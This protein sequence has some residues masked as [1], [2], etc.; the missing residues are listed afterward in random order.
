MVEVGDAWETLVHPDMENYP[1]A[2]KMQLDQDGDPGRTYLNP[3]SPESFKA[4]CLMLNADEYV[5]IADKKGHKSTIQGP[6][7]F[8]PESYGIVWGRKRSSILIPRRLPTRTARH[9]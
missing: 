9:A 3:A 8:K 2:A 4:K 1:K 5:I 6:R 7:V